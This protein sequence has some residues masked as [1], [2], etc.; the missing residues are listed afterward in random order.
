MSA[1]HSR[2]QG[3][4][5][6]HR[7]LMPLFQSLE[8]FG[9]LPQDVWHEWLWGTDPEEP[10][11]VE[12]LL[13]RNHLLA[14]LVCRHK[15]LHAP[16][17]SAA[18]RHDEHA[19]AEK[20]KAREEDRM[21][22]LDKEVHQMTWRELKDTMANILFEWP[23]FLDRLKHNMRPKQNLRVVMHKVNECACRFGTLAFAAEGADVMD[24]PSE[25]Q[26][27][28]DRSLRDRVMLTPGALRRMAGSLLIMY[29][30]LH[31][32][33]VSIKVPKANFDP[34]LSKYHYE[35]SQDDF[36]LLCMHI[37][38]PVAARLNY[39]HDF[40]G[41][42]NHVSQVVYFHNSQYIREK[43]HPIEDIQ[44]APAAHILPAIRELYPEIRLRFEEDKFDPTKPGK[45]WYW[46]MIAGRV[47]LVTPEPRVL[48]SDNVC[49]LLKVFIDTTEAQKKSA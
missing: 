32:L 1:A 31:L 33:S 34:G 9:E 40:P 47:Y 28:T 14:L 23:S 44:N 21:T 3:T 39:R 48:H 18:T 19:P 25:T 13:N 49:D 29:R 8:A 30:H 16:S 41:M 17:P 6:R 37:S 11:H 35:A 38:L 36:N 42:Y 27:C 4:Q 24:D 26:P 2:A 5:Q 12:V 46:L 7:D 43:R 10:Y 45:E 20:T 22:I 15:A